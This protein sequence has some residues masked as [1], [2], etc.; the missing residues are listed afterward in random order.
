MRRRQQSTILSWWWF[1]L[2]M[3][4][5]PSQL[6]Y[7]IQISMG[8]ISSL[9]SFLIILSVCFSKARLGTPYRRIIFFISISDLLLSLG[10]A[11]GPFATPVDT[12]TALWAI[13]NTQTCEANGFI[14]VAGQLGVTLYTTMLGIYFFCKRTGHE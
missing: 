13:G 8:L 2:I 1:W 7:S 3:S 14:F 12:P 5:T 11:T 10:L 9:A 4:S 6:Y